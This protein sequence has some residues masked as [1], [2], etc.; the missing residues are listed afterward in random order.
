MGRAVVRSPGPADGE[1]VKAQH[2]HHPNFRQSDPE[3]IRSLG[4]ARANQKAAIAAAANRQLRSRSVLVGDE[5]FGGANEIIEDILLFESCSR[6]V[7]LF[8][9]LATAPQVS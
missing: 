1:F 7:P 2:V 4:E 6:L 5:P 8:A 9:V 3:E